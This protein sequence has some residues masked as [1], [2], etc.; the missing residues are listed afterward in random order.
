MVPLA[1]AG[2]T[3]GAGTNRGGSRHRSGPHDPVP[4]G[5]GR[6]LGRT[7]GARPYLPPMCFSRDAAGQRQHVRVRSVQWYPFSLLSSAGAAGNRDGIC[8]SQTTGK[9]YAR[10]PGLRQLRAVLR[11]QRAGEAQ[12]AHGSRLCTVV[13]VFRTHTTAAECAPCPRFPLH[14]CAACVAASH[15]PCSIWRVRKTI[16]PVQSLAPCASGVRQMLNAST[17]P[18]ELS[19]RAC[20]ASD[21]RRRPKRPTPIT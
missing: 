9:G 2:A 21:L 17:T 4:W 5:R 3:G 6:R 10:H 11:A 16:P 12:E 7:L 15:R 1:H 19:R 14:F 8:S 18:T 13:E 20:T